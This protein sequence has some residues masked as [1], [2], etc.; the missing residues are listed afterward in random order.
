MRAGFYVYGAIALAA[1]SI[2]GVST[3]TDTATPAIEAAAKGTAKR[4]VSALSKEAAA[5]A[6]SRILA[7]EVSEAAKLVSRSAKAMNFGAE[8]PMLA[9]A[10]VLAVKVAHACS[11]F[12]GNSDNCNFSGRQLLAFGKIVQP[13]WVVWGALNEQF[14]VAQL[15]API[16]FEYEWAKQNDDELK[17][18]QQL[19]TLAWEEAQCEVRQKKQL[20]SA[21]RVSRW[22]E[23]LL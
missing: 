9:L 2:W 11:E 3:L 14:D 1:V 12:P 5:E 17:P 6:V 8:A 19:V 22:L 10:S 4:A 21:E 23:R 7:V 13:T 20:D 18:Y 15:C 16:E